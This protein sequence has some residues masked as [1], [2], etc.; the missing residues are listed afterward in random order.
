MLACKRKTL[1]SILCLFM[2]FSTS[3]FTSTSKANAANGFYVN[4][5]TLYDATGTPF[6]IPFCDKRNQS[7]SLLV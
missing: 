5:N 2:L 6:V 7:C 1:V 3:L 4:G